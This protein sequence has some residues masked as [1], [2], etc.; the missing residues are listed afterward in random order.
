MG[1]MSIITGMTGRNR[2]VPHPEKSGGVVATW[3]NIYTYVGVGERGE[4]K[5]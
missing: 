3:L 2:R 5:I 4:V 1:N